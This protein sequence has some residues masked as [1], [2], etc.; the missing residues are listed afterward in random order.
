MPEETLKEH[1]LYVIVTTDK[2]WKTED[3]AKQVEDL[4]I[5]SQ[6]EDGPFEEISATADPIN[7]DTVMPDA[8]DGTLSLLDIYIGFLREKAED[9]NVLHIFR[10]GLERVEHGITDLKACVR[11]IKLFSADM[12]S[13][14]LRVKTLNSENLD[15][16]PVELLHVIAHKMG[17]ESP[18]CA[19]M[20]RDDL[21]K[22]IKERMD[23]P[24]TIN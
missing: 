6:D 24:R 21:I 7:E 14:E 15:E 11:C 5:D 17:L 2:S 23:P 22:W 8:V 12:Q 9:E 10:E 3:V 19:T 16:A 20:D 13:P 4:L 18:E 1:R